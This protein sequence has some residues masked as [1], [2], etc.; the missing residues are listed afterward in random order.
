MAWNMAFSCILQKV[1]INLDVKQFFINR[2]N[3][4]LS[5]EYIKDF[6]VEFP[7]DL[8]DQSRTEKLK[9]SHIYLGRRDELDLL[10]LDQFG[11]TKVSRRP[12]TFDERI[13]LLKESENLEPDTSESERE[14]LLTRYLVM[15]DDAV[16]GTTYSDRMQGRGHADELKR[17]M[18][19]LGFE[20]KEFEGIEEKVCN[21]S[22]KCY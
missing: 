3:V 4:L 2:I 13:T 12:I 7:D 17:Y 16:N 11:L 10:L 5:M 22:L 9:T 15:Y 19:T 21:R 20:K 1:I 8:C 18:I 6:I 14:R